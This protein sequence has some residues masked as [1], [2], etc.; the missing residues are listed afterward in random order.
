[1]WRPVFVFGVMNRIQNGGQKPLEGCPVTQPIKRQG[2]LAQTMILKRVGL[3][4]KFGDIP[5]NK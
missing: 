5:T 4:F 3:A 2:K 1:M